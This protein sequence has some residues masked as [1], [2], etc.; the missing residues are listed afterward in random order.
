MSGVPSG[1][2]L[3]IFV[4]L[5]GRL[6]FPQSASLGLD[7]GDASCAV[8]AKITYAGVMAGT[9]FR[10]GSLAL[11]ELADL[12][13]SSKQVERVVRRVGAERCA[14]RDAE[15]EAFEQL[16]LVERKRAPEG[17]TPPELAVVMAD[18]GRLQILNRSEQNASSSTTASASCKE[19]SAAP[20]TLSTEASPEPADTSPPAVQAEAAAPDVVAEEDPEEPMVSEP[21]SKG[22][23]WRED[24]VAVL[25]QMSS[26]Q[27]SADPCPDIPKHFIDP[28]RIDKLMRELKAKAKTKAASTAEASDEAQTPTPADMTPACAEASSPASASTVATEASTVEEPSQETNHSE[29]PEQEPEPEQKEASENEDAS[30]DPPKVKQ[31]KVVASRHSWKMFGPIMA[32]AAWSLGFFAAPR[33]AFVGDGS[34]HHWGVW[35]RHFSNFVPILDFIHAASYVYAAALAGQSYDEGWLVYVRWIGW[36]WQ[37]KVSQVIEEL[38]QRQREVGLPTKDDKE[39]SLRMVVQ[40]SLTYLENHQEQMKYSEYRRD[41]LPITSSHI[42]SE[43]KRINYR[44]KGTEK[45]W[46]EEGAEWILQ[47]R[48]DYL[49]DDK[50]IEAFWQKRQT[51]ETGQRRYRKAG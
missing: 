7:R 33:R 23:H 50:P 6:F 36:V 29:K 28:A 4:R 1:S 3:N 10:Q 2:N 19:P 32:A 39:G 13:V 8:L 11:T 30:W 12:D 9:S 37:G 17:V 25:L 34:S 47:L 21:R 5:V 38:R 51:E 43:I 18:G 45:F 48:A 26:P 15:V 24:K 16:P 27:G 31:R 49:S 22:K 46:S 42:E 41:G 40:E 35:R 44:V 14:Q 20:S